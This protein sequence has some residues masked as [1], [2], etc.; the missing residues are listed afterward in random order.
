MGR[1]SMASKDI[2]QKSLSHKYSSFLQLISH[3]K[4][5]CSSRFSH[6]ANSSYFAASMQTA[7]PEQVSD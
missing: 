5:D 4:Q 2:G 6:V 1:R 7:D 3:S